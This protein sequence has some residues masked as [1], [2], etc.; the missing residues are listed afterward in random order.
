MAKAHTISARLTDLSF[1]LMLRS[2]VIIP[3]TFV[4]RCPL[5]DIENVLLE[6][7]AGGH[8]RLSALPTI[9]RPPS[10]A[11]SKCD[12]RRLRASTRGLLKVIALLRLA[13]L[14]ESAVE[15]IVQSFACPAYTHGTSLQSPYNTRSN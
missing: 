6:P 15:M 11:I 3:E 7:V 1:M 2:F 4:I 5:L 8:N 13:I 10:K 12:D 9:P 14:K